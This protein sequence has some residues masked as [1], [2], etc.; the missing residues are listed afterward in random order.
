MP[1]KILFSLRAAAYDFSWMIILLPYYLNAQSAANTTQS[2]HYFHC[3]FVRRIL[4]TNSHGWAICGSNLRK[5]P[6]FFSSPKPSRPA[7]RLTQP[8]ILWVS[9][10]S[11]AGVKQPGHEDDHSPP[12][13]TEVKNEWSCISGPL[14]AFMASTGTTLPF[15][16]H[17][18]LPIA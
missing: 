4:S 6:R 8:P 15:T 7:L 10:S 18:P 5:G 12:S 1:S 9:R 11:F 14:H 2:S 17:L 3:R 16:Y 13:G